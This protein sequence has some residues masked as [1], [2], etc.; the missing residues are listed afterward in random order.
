VPVVQ[1]DTDGRIVS[2][3]SLAEPMMAAS[4]DRLERRILTFDGMD[5]GELVASR[6]AGAEIPAMIST[7]VRLAEGGTADAAFIV[8]PIMPTME[9][10][11]GTLLLGCDAP[12]GR[13][14]VENRHRPVDPS[15]T[16]GE[17]SF[18]EILSALVETLGA[19]AGAVA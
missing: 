4:P 3:N 12:A 19:D 5:V 2:C 15:T 10:Q 7:K 16:E 11:G 14:A 17:A 6:E 9:T 1:Y 8:L 13:S 18:V